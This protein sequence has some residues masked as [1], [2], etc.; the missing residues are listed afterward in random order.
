MVNSMKELIFQALGEASMCWEP[1]PS[2]QVFDSAAC[3]KVGDRLLKDI[4]G[5]LLKNNPQQPHG[6]ICVPCEGVGF[7]PNYKTDICASCGGS[8]KTSPC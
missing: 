7:D 5:L 3:S 2:S 1:R 6:E 4:L 8:G